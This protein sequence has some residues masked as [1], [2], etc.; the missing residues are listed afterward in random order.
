M[1][2]EQSRQDTTASSDAGGRRDAVADA[3]DRYLRLYLKHHWVAAKG[4]LDLVRRCAQS[5]S[6][7]FIRTR[8]AE[9]AAEI[10]QDREELRSLIRVYG[11]GP[12]RLWQIVVSTGERLGRLKTNGTL[13]RRSPLS[14]VL[15]LEALKT[16]VEAKKGG[17]LALRYLADE[18]DRLDA[19]NLDDLVVR[20]EEQARVLEELHRRAVCALG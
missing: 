18:D 16:A 5:Q 4:G 6:D 13:V 20:A 9:I 8:L 11:V 15:E 1:T 14:D 12:S 17:W 3:R 7:P 19:Q 2:P 10:Q